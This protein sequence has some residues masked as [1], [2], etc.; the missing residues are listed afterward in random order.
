MRKRVEREH[1]NWW[2]S[3]E[4]YSNLG[5]TGLKQERTALKIIRA[6]NMMRPTSSIFAIVFVSLLLTAAG[7]NDS[8]WKPTEEDLKS[9][10][11]ADIQVRSIASLVLH[12]WLNRLY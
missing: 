3:I 7:A 12:I 10:Y 5:Q 11:K 2:L 6:S 1:E 9:V 8:Y 4:T